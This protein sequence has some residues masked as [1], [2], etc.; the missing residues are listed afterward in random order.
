MRQM[1]K[2]SRFLAVKALLLAL[3]AS[4]QT[5]HG[6]EVRLAVTLTSTVSIHAAEGVLAGA[7]DPTIIRAPNGKQGYYVFATGSGT[8]V[9]FS[10]DLLRWKKIA[11]VFDDGVPGWAREAVPGT[12]GI[13]APDISCRDG[14]YRLYYSVSTFGSQRSVIGLAV[15]RSVDPQD[16][17]YKWED[18]G[19]GAQRRI[20]ARSTDCRTARNLLH[21]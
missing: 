12:R 11:R 6:Q 10:P 7:P 17:A 8:A 15:N 3:F 21:R 2:K 16:S 18:R 14:L 13:W 4:S 9:W 5:S 1:A 20:L 19:P